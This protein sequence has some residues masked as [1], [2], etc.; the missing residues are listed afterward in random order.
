[1]SNGPL[2][3]EYRRRYDE[4]L[5]EAVRV[6]TAAARLGRPEVAWVDVT[7]PI[8]DR[9]SVET[10][11][12]VP[13]D[14][15]DFAA[16][17]LSAVAANLGSSDALL[18]GRPGSWE[19]DLVARLVKGTVGWSDEYLAEHRLPGTDPAATS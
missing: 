6:L 12:L 10:G 16:Q 15:A 5:A 17:A 9:R 11:T 3:A 2:V 1:M 4:L 14:F 7:V 13:M 19:A 8:E 18:A